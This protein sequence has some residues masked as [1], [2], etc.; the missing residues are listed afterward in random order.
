MRT[1]T[2]IALVFLIPVSAYSQRLPRLMFPSHYDLIF[3]P[4]LEE[5][6]FDGNETISISVQQPTKEIV[7]NSLEIQFKNVEIEVSS[8]NSHSSKKWK[9]QVKLDPKKEFA[10]ITVPDAI[11]PGPAFIQI[12][13][14][15]KLNRQLRGF[16]IGDPVEGS[17]ESPKRKYAASQGESTDIR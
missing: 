3:I 11:P 16:Y 5:E 10:I 2:W 1:L 17:A 13:Y 12:E 9:A 4:H 7:L 15:G 8:T 14:E 6:T